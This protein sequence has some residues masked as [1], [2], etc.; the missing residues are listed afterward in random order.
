MFLF[1]LLSK[2]EKE[3]QIILYQTFG[4]KAPNN[5]EMSSKK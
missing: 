1:F 3:K 2:K 4:Q 5:T